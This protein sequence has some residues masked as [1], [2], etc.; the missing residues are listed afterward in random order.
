MITMPAS[1]EAIGGIVTLAAQKV[2]SACV[3]TH[4]GAGAMRL[5]ESAANQRTNIAFSQVVRANLRLFRIWPR[6]AH[7]TRVVR[8]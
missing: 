5:T 8:R 7:D 6:H 2:P 1:S 4:K 3:L